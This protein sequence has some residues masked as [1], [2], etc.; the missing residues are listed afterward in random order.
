[1][2]VQLD[3]QFFEG[4]AQVYNNFSTGQIHRWTG[5]AGSHT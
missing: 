1:M 2:P 3:K 4:M 5:R